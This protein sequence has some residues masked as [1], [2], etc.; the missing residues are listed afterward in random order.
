MLQQAIIISFLNKWKKREI[1]AKIHGTNMRELFGVIEILYNLVVMYT[2][3]R[4]IKLCS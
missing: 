4:L 2:F 1:S 3:V